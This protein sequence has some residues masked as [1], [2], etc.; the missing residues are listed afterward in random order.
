[1]WA[2]TVRA[3]VRF[4]LGGRHIT[5]KEVGGGESTRIAFQIVPGW[6]EKDRACRLA[7]YGDGWPIDAPEDPDLET[8]SE[9]ALKWLQR[10]TAD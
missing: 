2:G 6:D 10:D 7:V 1:M 4:E 3:R 8:I 5:V 9:L